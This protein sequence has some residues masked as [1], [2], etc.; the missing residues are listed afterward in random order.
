MIVFFCVIAHNKKKNTPPSPKRMNK[1][2]MIKMDR[3]PLKLVAPVLDWKIGPN[4]PEP[5]S[6]EPKNFRV[7]MTPKS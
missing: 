5:W 4:R 1:I 6:L 7:E 2:L 3:V